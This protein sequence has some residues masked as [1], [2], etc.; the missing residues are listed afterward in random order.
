MK[1]STQLLAISMAIGTIGLG[2]LAY[3]QQGQSAT[4][5]QRI[6][7]AEVSDGDGEAND[8]AEEQQESVKLQSLAKVTAQQAQRSAEASLGSQASSVKLENEDGNVV[9]AV[10]IGQKEVKVDAGNGRVLYIE[11]IN[12]EDATVAHPRSSIRIADPNEGESE[13]PDRH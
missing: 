3:A 5:F 9:Y 11:A 1:F 13:T 12:T 2:S 10:T 8:V 7:L 6:Q 4:R